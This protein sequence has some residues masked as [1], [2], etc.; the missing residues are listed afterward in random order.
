MSSEYA[1]EFKA[2]QIEKDSI[3]CFS[4]K[5][6]LLI[7]PSKSLLREQSQINSMHNLSPF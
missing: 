2:K 1:S 5:H 4:K 7:E 6:C 3:I